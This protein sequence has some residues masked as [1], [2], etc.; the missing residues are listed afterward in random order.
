MK[1]FF[2]TGIICA[3]LLAVLSIIF[4]T[5]KQ[6]TTATFII[7]YTFL[8][9]SIAAQL[10]PSALCRNNTHLEF[11]YVSEAII[12]GVYFVIQF[13]ISL[14]ALLSEKLSVNNI[15]IYEAVLIGIFAIV[16]LI[17]SVSSQY[18]KQ[19]DLSNT[20][21]FFDK[22]QKEIKLLIV[23]MSDEPLKNGLKQILD[24]MSWGK[25]NPESIQT[26]EDIMSVLQ[27]IKAAIN[28]NK[29]LEAQQLL[30]QLKI[31]IQERNILCK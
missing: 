11:L 9:V 31:L 4:F 16:M 25:T 13:I 23:R 1:K 26:E 28:D 24:D 21:N 5:A 2:T 12:C 30:P 7:G 27:K 22:A 19:E 18:I 17:M 10:L 29:L 6:E 8:V 20:Y 3:I 14:T 15:L